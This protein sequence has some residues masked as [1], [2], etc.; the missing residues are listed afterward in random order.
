MTKTPVFKLTPEVQKAAKAM[1]G[2]FKREKNQLE[3]R[4]QEERASFWNALKSLSG[5]KN[6]G[7]NICYNW[8]KN[9][10]GQLF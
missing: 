7:C 2:R 8:K 6:S 9:Q 4:H 1:E 5:L 3:A 10:F